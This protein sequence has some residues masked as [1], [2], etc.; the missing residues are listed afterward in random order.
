MHIKP[1]TL[2]YKVPEIGMTLSSMW[3]S[4]HSPLVWILAVVCSGKAAS[5]DPG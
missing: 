1:L 3:W 5:S 2:V 4:L